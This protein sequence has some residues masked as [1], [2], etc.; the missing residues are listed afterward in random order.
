VPKLKGCVRSLG[1]LNSERDISVDSFVCYINFSEEQR[2]L[3]YTECNKELFI[4][5]ILCREDGLGVV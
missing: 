5:L 2:G 1:T 4:Q 3:A